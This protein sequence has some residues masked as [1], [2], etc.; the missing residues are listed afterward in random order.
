MAYWINICYDAREPQFE[1]EDRPEN[2]LIFGFSLGLPVGPRRL[3]TR[4]RETTKKKAYPDIFSM[5]GLNAVNGRFRD[6]VEEFEPGVHQFFPLELLKKNGDR[7]EGDYFIFNCAVSFDSLLVQHSEV[8]WLDTDAP[9]LP[10]RLLIKSFWR[11]VHS[12][13]A[14]QGRHIWSYFRQ[15]TAGLYCSDAFH[16]RLKAGK[17]KYFESAYCEEIDEPWIAEDN[18][19]PI[20]DWEAEHG[21]EPGMKPALQQDNSTLF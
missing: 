12:R 14:I 17:F 2:K 3:P 18:V 6:L 10:P 15:R 19:K 20:L 7:I 13:P 8:K 9:Y 1:F 21:F 16:Q 11:N 4:A 5:P